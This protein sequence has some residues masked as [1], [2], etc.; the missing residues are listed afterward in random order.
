MYKRQ[1]LKIKGFARAEFIF[2]EGVPHFIEINSNP[3]LSEASILPQ[4]S[5]IKGIALS[6]LFA[7]EIE[8]CL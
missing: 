2:H 4:Q 7:N 1:A 5:V 8:Q 6:E 3:G